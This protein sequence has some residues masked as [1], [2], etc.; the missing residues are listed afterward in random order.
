VTGGNS[1]G[2]VDKPFL[3]IGDAERDAALELLQSHYAAGRL[4]TEEFE[5]RMSAVLAAHHQDELDALF[6]DLPADPQARF[7][8]ETGPVGPAAS[9]SALT[10]WQAPVPAPR[11]GNAHRT[12]SVVLGTISGTVW[13]VALIG[14]L[15][16]GAPWRVVLI[17]M[18]VSILTGTIQRNLRDNKAL[19][20]GDED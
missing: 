1:I 16:F 15:F 8:D 11:G 9:P 19:P 12:L 7:F 20:P 3:R 13:P 5:E 17:A 6:T 14:V 2:R 18:V 4:S 10:P